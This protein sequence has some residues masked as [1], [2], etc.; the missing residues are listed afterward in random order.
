MYLRPAIYIL[1]KMADTIKYKFK[2]RTFQTTLH[3]GKGS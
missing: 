1:S 3:V 2:Y